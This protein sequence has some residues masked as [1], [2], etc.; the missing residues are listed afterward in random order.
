M[1]LARKKLYSQT[2]EPAHIP[3][4]Q[5]R[6]VQTAILLLN[7]IGLKELSMR[8]IADSLGVK[9]ASLYYHVK[10]KDEL[11]QLLC[12]TISEELVW[13]DSSLDWKEQ[14]LQW[15]LNFR[16]LL[17]AYRDSVDIFLSSIAL[18]HNRLLQIEKLFRLL[19]DAGFDD[20]HIPW[21]SSMLKNYVFGFVTEEAQ[22]AAH[23]KAKAVSSAELTETY[24]NAYTQLPAEHF[25][26]MTRLAAYTTD[27]DWESEFRYG[28]GVLI[29]GFTMRLTAK[30]KQH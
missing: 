12:D 9:T 24:Q 3:L 17:Q 7:E 10:D 27:P 18:S 13:P 19:A 4:D 6:I 8:K 20:Q 23:A 11:L 14:L 29:D 15:G 5:R 2:N 16:Q 28:M 22:M 25:P 30:G 26:T 21:A 1:I